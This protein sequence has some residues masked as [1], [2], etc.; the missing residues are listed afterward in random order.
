M[1]VAVGAASSLLPVEFTTH[2][3]LASAAAGG[4][5]AYKMEAPWWAWLLAAGGG[6]VVTAGAQAISK[7]NNF[8]PTLLGYA[9]VVAPASLAATAVALVR[10]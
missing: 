9:L 2:A 3:I 8:S 10:K 7:P 4:A 6:L 1:S 5:V